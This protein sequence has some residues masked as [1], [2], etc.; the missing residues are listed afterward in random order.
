[1]T[2]RPPRSALALLDWRLPSEWREI[3]LGDLVEEFQL[4][5]ATSPAAARRWFWWQ[6]IRCAAAP[7]PSGRRAATVPTRPGDSRMRSL[8]ADLRY[9]CRVM[10]RTPG[11]ALAV[12]AVLAL[13]IGAN[14]AIF[15][16]VNAVLLRP[17]PLHEPERLVRIFHR[18]PQDAFPGADT[19]PLSPANFYDWQRMATSFEGMAMFRGG[20]VLTLVGKGAAHPVTGGSVGAGFFD[21]VRARPLLGRV[22][23]ADEDAPGAP[24]VVILSEKF[25]RSELGAPAD[26]VGKPL[27][28]NDEPYTVVGVMPSSLAVRAWGILTRDVW[29]PI[30]LSAEDRAVRE[31][32]NFAAV[33]RLK[34]GVTLESASTELAVIA[35][36]LETAYP[37]ANAGWGS[38][39]RPLQEVVV[40]D[41]RGSLVMLL[42]AVGL[43]LL[44][45]C[46]NV[47]NLMFTRALARRKEIAVRAALGAGRGRVFQ[48]LLAEA[49]VLATIGG[50]LGIG[51]AAGGLTASARLLDGQVPRA[52]EIGI[53]WR[54]LLFAAAASILT[55]IVAG[56]LPAWRA[57]RGDLNAAL[58]EG[59]RN[60]GAVG[61][62][63]R[64]LLIVG[65]VALSLVLLMGAGVMVQSL[66]ALR[67]AD[68][69]FDEHQVLTMQ[70]SLPA[71]RYA[72]APQRSAF[73]DT[74][75]QRLRALPGVES[76]GT[77]DNVPLEGGSVQPIVLEGQAERLPKDQP[78]VQVRT[79]TPGY[80]RAMRIPVVRGRDLADGDDHVMLV[81]RGAAR[82]LWGD[83]D[84]VGRSVTLPLV[85]RM[86]LHRVVGIVG[87]VKQGEIAEA[88]QPTVYTY[89]REREA[90]FATIVLRTSV[91]PETITV[92]ATGVIRAMD[93]ELPVRNIRTMEQVRDDQ[94]ASRRFSAL[95]LGCF[96]IGALALASAGIYSVLSYIVRGR[97]REIGIRTAL[98]AQ[99]GHVLRLV[100]AEG[101][102]P[103]VIG[104]VIGGVAAL[105]AARVLERLVFGISA[106]DPV[107]LVAVAATLAFVALLA[108]L[109]PAWRA[110]RLDPLKVLRA[111]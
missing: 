44:I 79:A 100:L 93:P 36:R 103:A 82:L 94:L 108:S 60:D 21:I 40:G 101:M 68:G 74:A 84:P 47:G 19:F 16:I 15:S 17:L 62:R 38:V 51:I 86:Q 54:V 83:A 29:F 64:R 78:T 59:G 72:G 99:T 56:A 26:I 14:T 110:A 87:D 27:R 96:A 11:Y 5:A 8:L 71:T 102:S 55:G 33:G 25:W 76:V 106:S 23:R 58:K 45:A 30:A 90:P 95:L 63:T 20:R 85:S 67:H 31:N 39:L 49:L 12:I 34:P 107:T 75:L 37:E 13:G 69:G 91:P 65:E 1:V 4:R 80:L 10:R 81:S 28:L 41:V 3:V 53:D 61:V 35:R 46:A 104:I 32:H 77:I 73:F 24:K 22:F 43:V 92:P 105:L 48:Q 50:V 89:T 111:D 52:N 18:P 88:P 42:G 57:G 2:P 109:V 66:F 6:A 7:P 98:G 70:I 9:A 97:S